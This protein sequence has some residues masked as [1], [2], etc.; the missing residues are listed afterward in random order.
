MC[1]V[2]INIDVALENDVA[3]IAVVARDNT[4]TILSWKS[5]IIPLCT[6]SFAEAS[7]AE[8]PIDLASSFNWLV[9]VF[10]SNAKLIM[11]ALSSRDNSSMWDVYCLLDICFVNLNTIPFWFAAYAPRSSNFLAHNIA[12]WFLF[13]CCNNLRVPDTLPF[14]IVL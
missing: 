2:K 10:S 8:F 4:G 7:A 5:K 1:W 14:Y 12:K 6:P 9:V 13:C 11:E 3:A